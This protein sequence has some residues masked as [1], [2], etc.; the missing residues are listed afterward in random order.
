M[1]PFREIMA[2][3]QRIQQ[4][5]ARSEVE[6]SAGGMVKVRMNGQLEV[7]AVSIDPE[8]LEPV[9]LE[10]LQDLVASAV[11]D[12]IRKA[13]SLHGQKIAGLAG[14]LGLDLGSLLGSLGGGSRS[15]EGG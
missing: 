1:E 14:G 2:S 7:L 10:M 6:G 3:A 5:L 11:A 13:K 9:D 8:V 12:A 4:E 15:G